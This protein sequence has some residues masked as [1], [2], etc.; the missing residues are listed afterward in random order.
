MTNLDFI[1]WSANP[2]IFTIPVLDHPVRWYGFLFALGFIVGQMIMTYIFNKE[3][4]DVKLVDKL[5]MY[6][7]VATIVGARLGHCLF[8]DP[9]YYLS[10]P[11]KLIAVWEGGLASHG[12]AIAL[13][14]SLYLFA[15]KYKFKYL[16]VLDR[17]AI[18]TLLTGAFIRFG[19]F[20]NS[21]IIGKPTGSEYGVVFARSFEDYLKSSRTDIEE[22]SF[23]KIEGVPSETPGQVPMKVKVK[24]A[25]KSSMTEATFPFYIEKTVKSILNRGYVS[26]HIYHPES[27]TIENSYNQNKRGSVGEF[28]VYGIPRYPAQLY[29]SI[30]CVF[31]FLIIAHIWYH[32]RTQVKDGLM[33]GVFMTLLWAE[34]FGDEF[35]KEVQEPWEAAL[36]INMG[37][38]LSIPLFI[39][40]LVVL[41]RSWGPREK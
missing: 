40:G 39:F 20:M 21:E 1:I 28:T 33:F 24:F 3:G 10:N 14:I 7:I 11:L 22:V 12:G 8:Y 13:F 9:I 4:E 6:V 32:H 5:T 16:W 31:I 15:R 19:N 23:E 17:V 38:I 25:K 2:D 30:A 36:P 18:I 41:I 34:R 27:E 35:F 37:Q 26:D 29:E